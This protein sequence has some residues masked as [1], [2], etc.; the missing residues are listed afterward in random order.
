[1]PYTRPKPGYRVMLL[2][3]L[4]AAALTNGVGV[5]VGQATG[6]LAAGVVLLGFADTGT[7]KVRAVVVPRT[8]ESRLTLGSGHFVYLNPCPVSSHA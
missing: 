2:A 4:L 7:G 6:V 8:R 1:M 3:E 5:T